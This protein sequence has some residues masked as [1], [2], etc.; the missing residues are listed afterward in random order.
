MTY[1]DLRSPR[2]RSALLTMLLALLALAPGCSL[3]VDAGD[4]DFVADCA[5]GSEGCRCTALGRC[6]EGL[7]CRLP[8]F[9]V[10]PGSS[11]SEGA[12]GADGGDDAGAAGSGGTT[13]DGGAGQAG[14]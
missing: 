13:G 9:C 11:R 12:S 1:L 2:G 6:D 10:D 3:I 7:E 14:S 8:G 5:A 4:Y